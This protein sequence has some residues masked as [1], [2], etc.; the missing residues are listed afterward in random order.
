MFE[1]IIKELV[2]KY[3]TIQVHKETILNELFENAFLKEKYVSDIRRST[4]I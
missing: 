3:L 2:D 1:N 4:T